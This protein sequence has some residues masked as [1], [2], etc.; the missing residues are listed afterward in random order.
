MQHPLQNLWRRVAGTTTVAQA[1]L[2]CCRLVENVMRRGDMCW[3]NGRYQ[4]SSD[5]GAHSQISSGSRM[6]SSQVGQ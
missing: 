4:P 3:N 5:A 2:D 1:M 6:I